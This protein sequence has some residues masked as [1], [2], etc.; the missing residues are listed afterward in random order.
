MMNA[1]SK[2]MTGV[3]GC[4][5]LLN[6]NFIGTFIW[7]M[8]CAMQGKRVMLNR[9]PVRCLYAPPTLLC[10]AAAYCASHNSQVLFMAEHSSATPSNN[11]NCRH[12]A[13]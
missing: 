9:V 12:R 13:P 5:S 6:D 11:R 10:F 3:G 2:F 8:P 1:D 7:T 4:G